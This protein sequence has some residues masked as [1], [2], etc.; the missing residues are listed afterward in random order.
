MQAILNPPVPL[1]QLSKAVR[2]GDQT[3]DVILPLAKGLLRS[4]ARAFDDNQR[5]ESA[6]VRLERLRR[7]ID[8][9]PTMHGATMTV[10][11]VVVATPGV[12]LLPSL[13]NRLVQVRL[14]RLGAHQIVISPLDDLR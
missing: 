12:T 3:T 10:L 2:T 14:V 8:L 13:L 4:G 11:C 5:R 1:H 9:N 7:A 6:P